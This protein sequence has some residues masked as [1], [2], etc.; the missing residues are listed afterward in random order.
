MAQADRQNLRDM[1]RSEVETIFPGE[2]VE[3]KQTGSVHGSD[4]LGSGGLMVGKPIEPHSARHRFFLD[5]EESSETTTFV[6]SDEIDQFESID[7]RQ[8]AFRRVDSCR[9]SRFA[10]RSQPQIP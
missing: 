3:M 8:Q 9:L 2:S 1:H 10:W 4:D 6:A 7:R 5:G